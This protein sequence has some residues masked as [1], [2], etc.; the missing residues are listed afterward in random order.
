MKNVGESVKNVIF[1]KNNFE[2]AA[3]V[4]ILLLYCLLGALAF[5]YF[6]SEAEQKLIARRKASYES[7]SKYD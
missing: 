7:I 3:L 2:R 4:L 1:S 5:D 6:E